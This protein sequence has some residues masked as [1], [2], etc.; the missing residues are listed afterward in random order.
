MP[1]ELIKDVENHLATYP[2]RRRDVV[3]M[4]KE[5]KEYKAKAMWILIGFVGSMLSIGIWVGTMQSSIETNNNEH[6]KMGIITDA[7]ERR[8]NALEVTNG[9]IR[10]RLTSIDASLI[11]IK[12]SLK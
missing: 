7:I 6:I 4:Q 3:E 1:H 10:A 11:E 12:Q 5:W 9:E 8:V 2:E